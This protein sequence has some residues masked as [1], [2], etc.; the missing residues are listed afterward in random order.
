MNSD[1][2]PRT[3][4]GWNCEAMAKAMIDNG[5]GTIIGITSVAGDRGRQSNYFYGSAKGAF[6]LYLQG[7]RNRCFQKGVH[8]M[9]VR[10][11]FVDT[12]MTFGLE[13]GIPVASPERISEAIVRAEQ[14]KEDDLYLPRFWGGIM[15]IIKRIPEPV[16][17]RL[18]L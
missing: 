17:K 13:T 16:F 10:L 1:G 6:S 12:R 15:G 7:L 14:R 18:S 4:W 5:R 2:G 3:K 8:V 11:G 9:T